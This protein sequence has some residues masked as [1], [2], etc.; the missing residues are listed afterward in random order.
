MIILQHFGMNDSP[1]L[2]AAVSFAI[3]IVLAE[4]FER[5]MDK[6]DKVL[7]LGK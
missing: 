7:K 6:L 1:L 3:T 2:F 5:G 4:V